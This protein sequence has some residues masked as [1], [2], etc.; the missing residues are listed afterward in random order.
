MQSQLDTLSNLVLTKGI[1]KPY[2][3][4]HFRANADPRVHI[5][6]YVTQP[7]S[8]YKIFN[9]KTLD[10][11]IAAVSLWPSSDSRALE[12]HNT[13]VAAVIDAARADNIDEIY[14]TPLVAVRTAL[15]SNLLTG[16]V[17]WD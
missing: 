10:E 1:V 12:S 5:S 11:A 3:E 2:V 16:E 9:W 14:V 8:D 17:K 6:F 7:Y 4:Y 13:R 15:S